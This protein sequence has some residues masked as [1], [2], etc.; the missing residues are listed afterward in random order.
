[1]KRRI[2]ETI[3]P[4]SHSDVQAIDNTSLQILQKVGLQ[5]KSQRIAKIFEKGGAEIDAEKNIVKIPEHLVKEALTHVPRKVT[6]AGRAETR[7]LLLE[8]GR[9][10]FGLGGSPLPLTLDVDS[11]EFRPSVSEDVIK[12]TIVGDALPNMSFVMALSNASE[13]PGDLAYVHEASL[14]IKNTTKPI[15]Y[16]VVG[17]KEPNTCWRWLQLS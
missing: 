14:V 10:Y 3:R 5:V 1:M 17:L 8:E 7:D 16:S 6:L 11:G 9:S 13:V 15:I 4:L 2:G 12:A